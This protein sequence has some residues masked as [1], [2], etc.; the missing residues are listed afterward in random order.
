[1]T[2]TT[3]ATTSPAFVVLSPVVDAGTGPDAGGSD[4]TGCS[5]GLMTATAT[6]DESALGEVVG[7][8]VGLG[9][10]DRVGATDAFGEGAEAGSE[11]TRDEVLAT[12]WIDTH[13]FSQAI[14]TE[15]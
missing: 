10:G 6:G 9:E 13:R 1:M 2:S 15:V 14:G 7:A 12:G 8:G 3:S 11:E 5:L 4:R